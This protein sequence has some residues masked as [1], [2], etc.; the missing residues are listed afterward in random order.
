M[1]RKRPTKAPRSP[2]FCVDWL[3]TTTNQEQAISLTWLKTRFRGHLVHPQ[4]PSFCGFHPSQLPKRTPRPPTLG[5]LGCG[6]LQAQAQTGGCPNGSIGSNRGKKKTFLKN[7]PRPCV[8]L[9]Q[10]FLD[11]FEPVVAHFGPPKIPKCLENGLFWDQKWVKNAFFQNSS[12]TIWGAQTGEMSPFWGIL[13]HFGPSEVQKALKVG[14]MVMEFTCN[15]IPL[16][17]QP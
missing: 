9:K 4:P 10:L 12:S 14:L 3:L 13:G 1:C 15:L 17:Q 7:D 11:R 5:P 2:K 8:T 16:C 6:K